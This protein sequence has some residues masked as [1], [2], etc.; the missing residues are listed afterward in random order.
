MRIAEN[1]LYVSSDVRRREP[2]MRVSMYGFRD[3][4]VAEGGGYEPRGAAAILRSMMF[5]RPPV[6]IVEL[7]GWPTPVDEMVLTMTF[8]LDLGRNTTNIHVL[9]Y[10]SYFNVDHTYHARTCRV[11]RHKPM[12]Q[13]TQRTGPLPPHTYALL[14]LLSPSSSWRCPVGPC[15]CSSSISS[16]I[17]SERR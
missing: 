13:R 12:P 2:S 16:L 1:A 4:T 14:E 7:A 9:S 8:L 15:R 6:I 5:A 11:R 17:T 10:E 3:M